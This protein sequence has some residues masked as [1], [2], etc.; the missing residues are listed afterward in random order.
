M[1]TAAMPQAASRAATG[2]RFYVRVAMVMVAIAVIGFLPT[3]W[4]PLFRGTLSVSPITHVHAALFYGWTLLFLGQTSLVASGRV[5]RHRELGVFGV[6]LATG[7]CFAGIAIAINSIHV[8]EAQGVGA[9]ARAFAIVPVTQVLFFAALFA[10]ALLN[11]KRPEVHQR[12]MLVATASLLIAAVGR[13][14]RLFLAP[15]GPVV[16]PPVAVTLAPAVVIDLIVVAGMVYDRRTR[17]RVH[18]VYWV[19]GAALVVV[20]VAR[21]PLAGTAAWEGVTRW[22]VSFTP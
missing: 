18:P 13:V 14:F 19:A 5:A 21:V 1:T 22:L 9:A 8:G 10:A 11:V 16:P 12:L 20:E 3:Y 6:A 4:I 2:R 7:M 15:P 17:G